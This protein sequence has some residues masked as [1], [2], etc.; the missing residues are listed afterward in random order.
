VSSQPSTAASLAAQPM[1]QTLMGCF[2]SAAHAKRNL[3]II[4]NFAGALGHSYSPAKNDGLSIRQRSRARKTNDRLIEKI[5]DEDVP[6]FQKLP[7]FAR[8]FNEIP[9]NGYAQ[10]S[11][12]GDGY[13]DDFFLIFDASIT[14]AM[15]ASMRV[16]SIDGAHLPHNRNDLRLLVLEGMSSSPMVQ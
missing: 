16:V 9:G 13:F 4:E 11:I 6:A 5:Y 3:D 15:H 7:T 12:D 2:K 8:Q 14:I 1:V 10:C